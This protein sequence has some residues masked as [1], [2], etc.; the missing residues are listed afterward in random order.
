MPFEA[1]AHGGTLSPLVGIAYTLSSINDPSYE[2]PHK[3]ERT[4]QG[5]GPCITLGRG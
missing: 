4:G 3:K 1:E 2:V 5:S